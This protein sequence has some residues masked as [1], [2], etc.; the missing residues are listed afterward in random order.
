MNPIDYFRINKT[1][2]YK[3]SR[4]TLI[5]MFDEI[6]RDP[7]GREEIDMEENGKLSYVLTA[8]IALGT[9]SASINGRRIATGGIS[10]NAHIRSVS[11]TKHEIVFRTEVRVEQYIMFIAFASV[12]AGLFVGMPPLPAWILVAVLW[13][14]AQLWFNY[15]HRSQQIALIDDLKKSLALKMTSGRF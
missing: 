13:P 5:A 6:I 1:V 4:K 10:V 11:E 9:A 12:F 2:T 7:Y 8:R 14:V 15:V 3:G